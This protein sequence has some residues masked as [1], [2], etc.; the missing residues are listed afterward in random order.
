MSDSHK[1]HWN[2]IVK[3][4][5][6]L[7]QSR[8]VEG[9]LMVGRS[10]QCSLRL[11]DRAISR[12]HLLIRKSGDQLIVEKKSEF[13]PLVV[14]GVQQIQANLQ[15]GDQ[16]QVGPFLIVI[17]KSKEVTPPENPVAH[18][19]PPKTD[20]RQK[21]GESEE[22]SSLEAT[23]DGAS[24]SEQSLTETPSLGEGPS[25]QFTSE[26][27][28]GV[29]GEGSADMPG[30]SQFQVNAD[31]AALESDPV[32]STS[33][34]EAPG[35]QSD[36]LNVPPSEGSSSDAGSELEEDGKT[37]AISLEKVVAKL[38]LKAGT[39][40]VTE[41][42]I[43]KDEVVIGRGKDCDIILED[44]KASRRNTIIRRAGLQFSVKDL[45][46]SNGTYLN[47][48]KITE[49]ELSSEDVIQVGNAELE[50]KVTSLDYESQQ[51]AFIAV[52]EEATPEA[53][54]FAD[55]MMGSVAASE[56]GSADPA[57]PAHANTGSVTAGGQPSSEAQ[58]IAGITGIGGGSAKKGTLL[59]KFRA[60]PK[61][62]Q[63]IGMV[64]G[65]LFFFWLLGDD[66]DAQKPKAKAKK[67]DDKPVASA[68]KSPSPAPSGASSSDAVDLGFDQLTPDKKKYVE[69]QH[70]LAFDYYKNKEYDK[71]L[72]E[73]EKV[74][75]MVSDY[76]DSREIE[77]YARE[78]KRKLE[79]IEEENRKRQEALAMKSKIA[80]QLAK[81]KELM[82]KKEYTKAKELYSEVLAV[83]PDNAQIAAWSKEVEQHEEEQKVKLQH[84]EAQ[85]DINRE[86]WKQ[87]QVVMGLK[88]KKKYHEAIQELKVILQ[89]GVTDRKLVKS[90]EATIQSCKKEIKALRDP[91]LKDALAAETANDYEKAFKLYQ[92]STRVDPQYAAGY[93]GMTRIRGFLHEKA[94]Q[95]YIEGVFAEGYSDFASA[96]KSYNDCLQIA[97]PEDIYHE[98]AKRKLAR[99]IKNIGSGSHQA[100]A[101]GDES[102]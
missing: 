16:I 47:G 66:E 41:L 69:A 46:S 7:I 24:S 31:G 93:A 87:Y 36:D 84:L 11:E 64:A 70:D 38:F 28:P 68:S 9:D 90:T 17:E 67:K 32:L 82:E 22:H 5:A 89:M 33:E 76:K 39:A 15:S 19:N 34:H 53:E 57:N 81:I 73:I 21:G 1:N 20:P 18:S 30:H 3:K 77:R 62:T 10:D 42:T 98:R 99:F 13:A 26:S 48:E 45:E 75:S 54:S 25:G 52:P 37:R 35:S 6:E 4:G 83:D 49:S 63:I 29:P 2:L 23:L 43:D 88:K 60:L 50:F 71:A 100:Q 40:N 74:F 12:Q 51:G 8:A 80:D 91:I 56:G 101:D 72:F 102:N 85:R 44:K 95:A 58:G 59:E 86:G 65:A 78:G 96:Q 55:Q 27:V 92:Q 97:P 14:N 94:K 61:R 79:A